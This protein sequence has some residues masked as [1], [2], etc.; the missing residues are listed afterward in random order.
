MERI[1]ADICSLECIWCLI[2][3][4]RF[5][6]DRLSLIEPGNN[7]MK[8]SGGR[9][10]SG[11]RRGEFEFRTGRMCDTNG[12]SFCTT[13]TLDADADDTDAA[14]NGAVAGG[15]DGCGCGCDNGAC[16]RGRSSV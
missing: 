6:C 12:I 3:D 4:F 8:L 15:C 9:R 14:D 2:G 5:G 10:T 13:V 7:G 11:R 1:S 16:A